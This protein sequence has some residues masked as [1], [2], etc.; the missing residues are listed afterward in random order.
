MNQVFFT[1]LQ[2]STFTFINTNNLQDFILVSLTGSQ[3]RRKK[4]AGQTIKDHIT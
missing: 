4:E 1:V 2:F 3:Y